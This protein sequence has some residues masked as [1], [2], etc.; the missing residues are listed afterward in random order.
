MDG[1]FQFIRVSWEFIRTLFFSMFPILLGIFVSICFS[2]T[3]LESA[4]IKNFNTGEVFIYTSAFLA[5]YI[6]ATR[7]DDISKKFKELCFYLFLYAFCIGSILF[8]S[9][10]VEEAFGTKMHM[11]ASTKNWVGFSIVL[12][13]IVV[14]YVSIWPN[15]RKHIDPIK[16]QLNQTNDLAEKM[17]AAIKKVNK[18]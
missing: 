18:I 1:L 12:S 17:S 15:H 7:K 11:E 4:L 5:P 9:V 13:T 2:G 3:S 10:R 16:A 14:W 6:L 8:L